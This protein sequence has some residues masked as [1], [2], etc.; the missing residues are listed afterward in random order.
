MLL[1]ERREESSF[2]IGYEAE[3]ERGVRGLIYDIDNTLVPHGAPADERTVELFR[4]LHGLGFS[5]C[6][7]SNNDEERVKPFAEAT[8]SAYIFKA[9]KPSARGYLAAMERM[10][11]DRDSTLFIGDQLLTDIFGA[12]RAGVRHILVEPVDLRSEPFHIFLKRIVEKLIF[13][14][15]STGSF[16]KSETGS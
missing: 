16:K 15:G 11:T 14:I 3:Y 2:T 12:N 9:G 5:T 6:F 7:V 8:E 1:P 13:R 4:K 10:G